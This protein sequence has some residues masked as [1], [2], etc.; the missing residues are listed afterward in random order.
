MFINNPSVGVALVS[1]FFAGVT[2]LVFG[3]A[4]CY[5]IIAAIKDLRKPRPGIMAVRNRK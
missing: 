4:A 1:A 2:V 3:T 5:G